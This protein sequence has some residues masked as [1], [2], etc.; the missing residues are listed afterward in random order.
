M[1]YAEHNL[2]MLNYAA[3][4]DKLREVANLAAQLHPNHDYDQI[5]GFI[6]SRL[7]RLRDGARNPIFLPPIVVIAVLVQRL[8]GEVELTQREFDEV[9]KGRLYEGM[10][11]EG[12]FVLKYLSWDTTDIPTFQR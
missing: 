9:A 3:F 7:D 12:A 2:R 5:K 10:N 1:T 8:G 6:N 4:M 11:V